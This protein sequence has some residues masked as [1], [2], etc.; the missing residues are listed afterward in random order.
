MSAD[1]HE[2]VVR[3][4]HVTDPHLM[5]DESLEIYDVNTA[6]SL[7]L[8]LGQ[9]LGPGSA[10]PDAVLVTGDIA[11][12]RT[13]EAYGHF[14]AQLQRHGLPVLCLPG[15]HDRP[16][17]MARLLEGEGFRYCARV[18]LAGWSIVALDSHVPGDP[19]GR[20]PSA[21]IARLEA[22]LRE[23]GGRH[24]AVCLHHPP[25]PV[26]SQWLDGVG[27]QNAADLLAVVDA[28][29]H[30]RLVVSGHVHQAFDAMRGPVRY[31]T[32]PSTC[33]QFTPRTEQCLMDLRPPGYRW[34]E[35]RGDGTIDTRVE[36][37]DGWTVTRRPTDDRAQ[38]MD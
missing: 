28:H 21:E 19:A 12:D 33:A 8:V 4:L 27:L 37:L 35:L 11:D 36:W 18:D 23:T 13:A 32:T 31:L 16:E 7:R 10:R 1:G 3:L 34:I 26:G 2:P 20:L 30:V 15:N 17:L 22:A 24:V 9:A 25:L 29:P 6:R 14:R 38:F 5:R